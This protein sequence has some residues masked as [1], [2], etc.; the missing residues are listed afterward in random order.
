MI[1]CVTMH[2]INYLYTYS[3]INV[4]IALK[5][6]GFTRLENSSTMYSNNEVTIVN[7]TSECSFD[8]DEKELQSS[9]EKFTSK[10]KRL[11]SPNS[12]NKTN[13]FSPSSILLEYLDLCDSLAQLLQS[14]QP[15]QLINAISCFVAVDTHDNCVKQF[16]AELKDCSNSVE[17]LMKLFPYSNWYDHSIIRELLEACECSEGIHLLDEFDSRIDLIQS[18]TEFPTFVPLPL[19]IPG[20]SSYHTVMAT[21]HKQKLSSLKLCHIG[22][23]KSE[24]LQMCNL[25]KYSCLFLSITKSDSTP[26][27]IYWLIPRHLFTSISNSVW[28][29]KDSFYKSGI[30]EI[31][32]YP[33]FVFS[34]HNTSNVLSLDYFSLISDVSS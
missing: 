27:I 29:F 13:Y 16:S 15:G 21:C 31:A 3:C 17:V 12:N 5:L 25:T 20:D 9:L 30:L 33:C 14:L 6:A 2:Y 24:M 11:L 28:N 8:Y 7:K 26:A 34:T 1:V 10:R 18:I 23:I 22:E 19:M 32:I 4:H